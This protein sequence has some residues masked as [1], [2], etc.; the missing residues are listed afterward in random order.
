[1]SFKSPEELLDKVILDLLG[2]LGVGLLEL[3]LLDL[4]EEHFAPEARGWA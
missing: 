2:A 3:K 1:M 4:G